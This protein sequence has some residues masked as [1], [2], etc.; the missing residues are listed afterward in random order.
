[1]LAYSYVT[2]AVELEDIAREVAEAPWIGLDLETTG[3]DPYVSRVRLCSINTGKHVYVIDAFQTGTLAPITRVLNNPTRASGT[4]PLVI[5]QNL[6]FDQKFLALHYSCWLWPVFDTWKASSVLYNGKIGRNEGHD[7]YSIYQRELPELHGLMKAQNLGASNWS[8]PQL[9]R[10]QLDYA[11]EDVTYMGQLKDILRAKLAEKSLLRVALLEF[12]AGWAEISMELNGMPFNQ[13]DWLALADV[14][15]QKSAQLRE[16][17]LRELPHPYG[18]Q[19]LFMDEGSIFNVDSG[20]QLLASLQRMGIRN[21]KAL[22]ADTQEETL[23]MVASEWPQAKKLIDYRKATKNASTYGRDFLKWVNPVTQRIHT[24][25]YPFTDAGRYSS[26]QPSLQNLPRD[27]AYRRC[28][29]AEDGWTFVLADYSQIELRI[30]AELAQDPVLIDVF[31]NNGDPHYRTASLL[32][33]IPESEVSK[34]QRQMAKPVNFGFIYGLGALRLVI[35]AQMDYG[36]TLSLDEA[37]GFR[38]NF[39]DAYKGVARFHEDRF[40]LD[41]PRQMSWTASGRIR[42]MSEKAHNELLNTPVQGTGADGLKNSLALTFDR[43]RARYSDDEVRMTHMVHDEIILTCR[44]DQGLVTEVKK[45]LRE[46]MEDGMQP[47]LKSVP[48]E[49]LPDAGRTWADAKH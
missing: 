9:T 6:N 31:R 12:K 34:A 10:A 47:Y 42:Y 32:L 46:S 40:R 41:K 38:R 36:V 2:R 29:A 24:H 26:S 13:Q 21:G 15:E 37:K 30:M 8:V 35:Y 49:A 45:L 16:E 23:A 1:M 19:S 20:P 25:Y 39:F 5:G 18:Q 14:S 4:R 48:V 28:F 7:L 33:G 44:E 11:A 27:N 3:L 22:I 43:I 17:L